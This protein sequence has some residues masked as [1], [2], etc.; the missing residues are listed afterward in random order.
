MANKQ[1]KSKKVDQVTEVPIQFNAPVDMPSV[2]AT[3]I[4]LQQMEYEVVVSFYET[5]PPILLAGKNE[6]ENLAI[7]KKAGMR[8][9]CVAKVIIAKE[10]FGAFADIM[11]QMATIIKAGEKKEKDA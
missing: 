3:N 9:D 5:Q 2:Y 8:A 4:L 1:T 7:M 6:D 10:R 11:R